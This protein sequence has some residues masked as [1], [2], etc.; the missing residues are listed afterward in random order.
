LGVDINALYCYEVGGKCAGK[1]L[2]EKILFRWGTEEELSRCRMW[3]ADEVR[4]RER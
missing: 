1:G 2:E 3:E 4:M